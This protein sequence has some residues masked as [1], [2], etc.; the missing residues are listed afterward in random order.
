MLGDWRSDIAAGRR[1]AVIFNAT[2]AESG[3]RFLISP[4][5][6][7]GG[8]ARSAR[9]Y[10]PRSDMDVVLA[11]RLSSTFPFVTPAARAEWNQVAF[12]HRVPIERSDH[13]ADG[14]YYDNSGISS[15]IDWLELVRQRTCRP[16]R[17]LFVVISPSPEKVPA[18]KAPPAGGREAG[19]WLRP[20]FGPLDTLLS[21]RN[22]TQE[23]RN[24]LELDQFLALWTATDPRSTVTVVRFA[25]HQ[26]G[27]LSWHLT[28]SDKTRIQHAWHAAR[29][30][31][32]AGAVATWWGGRATQAMPRDACRPPRRAA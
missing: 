17:V 13:L 8:Q 2:I 1:P 29:N 28:G 12:R 15:L 16:R 30:V 6:V 11:A 4:I 7:N 14:G 10:Y 23:D 18:P 25:P 5:A 32:A 31:T 22:A 27:P 20:V 3:Y 26:P 24:S 21:A 9:D 19:G